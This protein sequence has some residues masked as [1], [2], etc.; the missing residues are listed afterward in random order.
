MPATSHHL[1]RFRCCVRRLATEGGGAALLAS[2]LVAFPP[3]LAQTGVPAASAAAVRY[4]VV[5][6]GPGDL[7]TTPVINGGGQVAFSLSDGFCVDR[8][9]E[10]FLG[11]LEAYI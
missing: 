1:N 9:R 11:L 4:R 5:N 10:D 7:S 2:L 6:L 3:V 8:H